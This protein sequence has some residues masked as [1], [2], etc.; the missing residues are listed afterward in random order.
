MMMQ[1]LSVHNLGIPLRHFR[2]VKQYT[3]P[4]PV[5]HK[6]INCTRL[7][8]LSRYNDTVSFFSDNL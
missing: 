1:M 7:I 5:Y 6:T 4:R 2:F 3:R 8:V